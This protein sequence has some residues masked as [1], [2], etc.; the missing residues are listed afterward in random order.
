MI[1][2]KTFVL[3]FLIATISATV[4]TTKVIDNEAV[5]FHESVATTDPVEVT[6]TATTTAD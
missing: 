4:P 6:H 2:I 5:T 1:N 3:L